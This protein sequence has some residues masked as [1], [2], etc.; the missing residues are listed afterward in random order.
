MTQSTELPELT[1]AQWEVLGRYARLETSLDDVRQELRSVMEFNFEPENRSIYTFFRVPEPGIPITREHIENA[2]AKKRLG[3]I[4]ERDL[5]YWASMLLLNDAYEFDSKEEEFI[6]DWLNDI[7]YNLDP[8][9]E[10]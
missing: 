6:A 5:V 2:L 4:G 3:Q 8:T 10:R 7:S 9:G 1:N